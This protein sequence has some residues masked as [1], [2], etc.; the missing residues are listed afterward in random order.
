[1]YELYQIRFEGFE[2]YK[3]NPF[4]LP[5]K[6]GGYKKKVISKGEVYSSWTQK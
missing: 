4:Y 5:T 6:S 2:H 3:K 1:M